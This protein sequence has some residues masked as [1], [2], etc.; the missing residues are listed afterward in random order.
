M[1]VCYTCGR[2]GHRT[3]V[4]P[5]P[6][7]VLCRGCGVTNPDEQHSCDPKC[8]L[9]GVAH[10]TAAKECK[11]RFQTPYAWFDA[12]EENALATLSGGKEA[13]HHHPSIMRNT[14]Q[15]Y[16]VKGTQALKN[17]T[18]RPVRQPRPFP[19]QGAIQIPEALQIQRADSVQRYENPHQFRKPH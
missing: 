18:H 4:Y 6:E 11:K 3:D 1:D 5:S 15:L 16:P 10:F 7:Q 14:F 2:L 8:K 13:S 17:W 12:K 9:C 19:I